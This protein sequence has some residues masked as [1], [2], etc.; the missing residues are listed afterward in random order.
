[1]V[2]PAGGT[3]F[4]YADLARHLPPGRPVFGL[5]AMGV[6]GEAEPLASVEEMAERYVEAVRERQP[7]GPYVLAG[8]SAGGVIAFEMA[9]RLRAAGEEVALVAL[10]DADVPRPDWERIAPDDAELMRRFARDLG[11]ASEERLDEL[12]ASLRS[13]PSDDRL[14]GLSEWIARSGLPIPDDQVAQIGRT[15]KVFGATV[16][17]VNAYRP[18]PYAGR[19]LLLQAELGIPGQ[20]DERPGGIAGAWREFVDRLEVR[21]VPGTHGTVVSEPHVQSVAAELADALDEKDRG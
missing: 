14:R 21:I 20:P 9:Q 17:A 19:V 5:Q 10:L 7:Q 11:E 6:A 2:H 8:W 12:A 1:V 3:V 4:R 18:A 13:M 16:R 15:V